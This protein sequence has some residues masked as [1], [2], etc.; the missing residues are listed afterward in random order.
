MLDV[1]ADAVGLL[2]DG[3]HAELGDLVDQRVLI[4]LPVL[5]DCGQESAQWGQG[6]AVQKLIYLLFCIVGRGTNT[7]GYLEILIVQDI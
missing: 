1:A 2:D 7:P 5:Q 6:A 3:V 4:P